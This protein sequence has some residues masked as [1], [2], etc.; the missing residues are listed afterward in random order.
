MRRISRRTF[1]IGLGLFVVFS[2]VLFFFFGT[3][4]RV[5]TRFG[6][7]WSHPYAR[8]LGLEPQKSFELALD[9][10]KPAHVRIPAYWSEIEKERGT[11]DWSE[12]DAQLDAT[13]QRGI[14]V[15]LVL[16][17][18]VPRWPE[19]WEPEWVK[20]LNAPERYDVQ[21]AYTKAVYARYLEHSSIVT[22]QVENEAFF[23]SYIS[24]PGLT[25][26]IVL[27]EMQL[28]RDTEKARPLEKR[29]P[30]IT[31]DSGE[32]S[33]WI[34]FLGK[35]DGIGIS[36]YRAVLTRWAGRISY[37]YFTPMFYW[38][39]AHIASQWAGPIFV[40][41]FQMEPWVTQDIEDTTDEEQFRTLDLAR[42]RDSFQYS[43]KLGMPAVDF[44]GVEWWLW[45]K[46]TRN[47]PEFWEEAKAFF[48]G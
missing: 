31:T 13:A 27:D 41:E 38:R 36:V 17:S 25:K 33:L 37:W 32:W 8:Q 30:V 24:C 29:R 26:N 34:G 47:H 42:M 40:S 28:V 35:V 39:R 1:L 4:P 18:R 45:M 22:W 19:C 11:Y 20:A 16:G 7:T 44:W 3:P 14:Q 46:Q 23:N 6:F 15:T 48:G 12:L 9:D 21:M 2:F 43:R 10:L 5:N